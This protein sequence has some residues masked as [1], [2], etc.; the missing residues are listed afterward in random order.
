M[1][2]AL[3]LSSYVAA[4]RVGGGGQQY[5]FAAFGIDPVLVPTVV[6]GRH[7]GK[8]APGGSAVADEVFASATEAALDDIALAYADAVVA[9]Y[10][11]SAE[12]VGTAARVIGRLRAAADRRSITASL[13]VVVDPIMGD[14]EGGL[15]V[16]PEVADAIAVELLPRAD[17]VT[18]NLWELQ[19]LTGERAVGPA[20]A[21]DAARRLP[22]PALVTSV[23]AGPGEIGA[24]CVAGGRAMFYAHPRREQA[25]KGTG[26]LVAAV[27]T[28]GLVG[29]A[30]PFAAAER[31]MRAT[32]EAVDAAAEWNAPELPLVALG[33]RI[34]RPSAALRVEEIA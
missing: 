3:I 26:D 13:V 25:P 10:F 11:A 28:A 7:P 31:A 6:F 27:F 14:D 17:W 5:A 16:K 12:Q 33:G 2:L 29:G 9:G 22:C 34:V 30:D 19:R 8:G 4:S 15:Y 18:P 24:V 1:P 32:A 21:V 20:S 23:P